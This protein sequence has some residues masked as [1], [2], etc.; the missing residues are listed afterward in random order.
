[1]IEGLGNF[2]SNEVHACRLRDVSDYIHRL[3]LSESMDL[4]AEYFWL[5]SLCVPVEE[6][7]TRK[8]AMGLMAKVYQECFAMLVIDSSLIHIKGVNLFEA[9]FRLWCSGWATRLWTL[10]EFSLAN[11]V[12]VVYGDELVAYKEIEEV[13]KAGDDWLSELQSGLYSSLINWR[14]VDHAQWKLMSRK[15]ESHYTLLLIGLAGRSTSKQSDEAFCLSVFLGIPASRILDCK[16]GDEMR[17]FWEQHSKVPEDIIFSWAKKF[18]IP[19]YRWAPRSVLEW[20]NAQK[21]VDCPSA[22]RDM[23]GISVTLPGLVLDPLRWEIRKGFPLLTEEG[24]VLFLKQIGIDKNSD[25]SYNIK[26]PALI[27]GREKEARW[28]KR[29]PL[30][31]VVLVSLEHPY[32]SKEGSELP[33]SIIGVIAVIETEDPSELMRSVATRAQS[34]GGSRNWILS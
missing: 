3:F 10:R 17:V 6:C 25:K 26:Y 22:K 2:S 14:S 20:A 34:T 29:R 27:Y 1:M 13:V 32:Q 4:E 12:Y 30:N 18:D 16:A 24:D 11:R 9:G 33:A 21:L 7:Q 19:G 8:K 28:W 15:N 31:S 5:D 23:R